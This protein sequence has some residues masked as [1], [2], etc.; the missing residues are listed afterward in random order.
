MSADRRNGQKPL[1]KLPPGART[2]VGVAWLEVLAARHRDVRWTLVG[3]GERSEHNTSTA[4]GKIVRTLT[5]PENENT[6]L[7]GNGATGSA[8]GSDHDGVDGGG[9]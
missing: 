3:P 6:I 7:N 4:A 8:N 1:G 5:T 9:K 2:A